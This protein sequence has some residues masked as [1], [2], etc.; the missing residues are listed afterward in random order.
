MDSR[1]TCRK[2]KP[3][4]HIE[5]FNYKMTGNSGQWKRR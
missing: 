4:H 5:Y 3:Q 2:C 1:S